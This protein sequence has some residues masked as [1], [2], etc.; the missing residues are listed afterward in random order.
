MKAIYCEI[1]GTIT[2]PGPRDFMPQ[3]CYCGA[4]RVWWTDGRAGEL[5]VEYMEQHPAITEKMNGAP[6]GKPQVWILGISNSFLSHP[7]SGTPSA[8]DVAAILAATP[9]NYVFKKTKSNIIRVRPGQTSDTAW[10]IF[11]AL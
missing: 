1:C 8:D 7:S 3:S 9:P 11:K 10:G 5:R 6:A 2:S 4:H